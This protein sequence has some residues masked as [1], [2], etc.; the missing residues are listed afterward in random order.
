MRKLVNSMNQV[1]L[2][3]HQVRNLL[4]NVL[5]TSAD[6]DAFCVDY[7]SHVKRRFSDG[8][9]RTSKTNLF[10]EVESNLHEIVRLLQAYNPKHPVWSVVANEQNALVAGTQG[11]ALPR[12]NPMFVGRDR[13][14]KQLHDMLQK[15]RG[16][17]IVALGGIGKSSVAL[18]YAHLYE[19]DYDLVFWLTAADN[20]SLSLGFSKLCSYLISTGRVDPAELAESTPDTRRLYALGWLAQHPGWL[21]ILDN[22]DNPDLL[23]PSLP[24]F[25]HGYVLGTT[26]APD[27]KR[28]GLVPFNLTEFSE[29]EGLAFL[30]RRYQAPED[31][32]EAGAAQGLYRELGGLPLALEQAG[33]YLA[34]NSASFHSYLAAFRKRRAKLFP[35]GLKGEERASVA[36]VWSLAFE[37]V[38]QV[39]AASADLLRTSA[40]LSP[41]LIPERLLSLG[42]HHLGENVRS[43]LDPE[44]PLAINTLLRPLIRHSLVQRRGTGYGV[45]RLVQD[46]VRL[47]LGSEERVFAERAVRALAAAFPAAEFSTWRVCQMLM[48][49]VE[50]ILSHIERLEL[51]F[52]EAAELLKEAGEYHWKFGRLDGCEP[53]CRRALAIHTKVL[54]FEHP[55]TA[56]S[57]NN[58]AAVFREQGKLVEAESLC[59]QALEIRLRV[60]GKEH[61]DTASSLHSVALLF[62]RMRNLNEAEQMFRSAL[63]IREGLPGGLEHPDTA[64]TLNSLGRLLLDQHRLDEAE[65]ICRRALLI[66][67]KLNP[68]HPDIAFT[69]ARL[70]EVLHAQEK[71]SEAKKLFEQSLGIYEQ[72]LGS[73]HPRTEMARREISVYLNGRSSEHGAPSA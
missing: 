43:Q 37:Q 19:K 21:L 13:E 59:R 67:E 9:D 38:E 7:F 2:N 14:I 69:M 63:S 52:Q 24:D 62:R 32:A 31:P 33:A 45:H 8:M 27:P 54:G 35:T 72:T 30:T 4:D 66:Y 6:L 40:F 73:D 50:E 55:D 11:K 71:I 58:L 56:T 3:T 44:D 57:L 46:V 25:Q 53:L 26:R 49:C 51:V 70:A 61:P 12:R 60:L 20:S 18:E 22:A 29:A 1:A 5:P 10:L 64:R 36:T 41:D 68:S 34:E 28:L 16:V 48:P 42:G 65:Q 23:Q 17:A 47:R 15:Q 39:S